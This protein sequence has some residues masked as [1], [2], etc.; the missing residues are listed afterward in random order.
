MIPNYMLGTTA[1]YICND[2]FFLDQSVRNEVRTCELEDDNGLDN[3]GDFTGTQPTC[4]R[5][6][7]VYNYASRRSCTRDTVKLT[8][9][10]VC[11]CVFQ[12]LLNMRNATITM[13][14]WILIRRFAKA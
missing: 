3:L 6:H 11:V 8:A 5:K 14:S 7:L 1:T 13:F 4:V 10:S 9:L 12:L 2:G